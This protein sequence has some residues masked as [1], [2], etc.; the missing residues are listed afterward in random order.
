MKNRVILLVAL[1]VACFGFCSRM[2]EQPE[3]PVVIETVDG[4]KTITNP[5]YPSE[6]R[7]DLLLTEDFTVGEGVGDEPGV[8]NQPRDL[9]VDERGYLFVLDA[10]DNNIKVYDAEGAY[11]HTIGKSGQG[12]GELGRFI[13]FDISPEGKV[14]VMDGMN[15]RISLFEKDGTF[16]SSFSIEGFHN[17]IAVA[18]GESIFLSKPVTTPEEVIGAEQVLEQVVTIYRYDLEGNVQ[19]TYGEYRGNLISYKRV[20]KDNVFSGSS[21]YGY[22]TVWDVCEG[23]RL[24]QGY[25]EHYKVTVHAADGSP[26]FRFGRQFTQINYPM[27][28]RGKVNPEFYP[29]FDRIVVFDDD[30]NIWLMQYGLKDPEEGRVYDIFSPDGIYLKQIYV[31]DRIYAVLNGKLYSII[32][33]EDE[34]IVARR[35][36]YTEQERQ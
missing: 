36:S 23:E 16:I 13:Y 21:P 9:K 31:P 15:R 8:L 11:S 5:D 4:V 30:N 7:F 10:G 28:G 12:P 20:S 18:G 33:T 22:Q 29:A 24:L 3:Y 27:Y 1:S 19:N 6:G 2:L 32:R 25:S 14:F 26:E 34:F 35:Y 17:K